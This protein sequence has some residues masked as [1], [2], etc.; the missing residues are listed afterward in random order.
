MPT[1]YERKLWAA[2]GLRLQ[3]AR[4]KFFKTASIAARALG[5]AGPTY[6]AHENGTRQIRDDIA[7]FYAEQFKVT[8]DWLLRGPGNPDP[9]DPNSPEPTPKPPKT[10]PP[11]GSPR[12][13]GAAAAL[14]EL[15]PTEL[16]AAVGGS[17][18]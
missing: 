1:D 11:S 10:T 6:L 12:H 3:E 13:P 14:R 7:V 17:R 16:P 2:Q 18:R 15:A 9:P 4:S 5:I 8:P